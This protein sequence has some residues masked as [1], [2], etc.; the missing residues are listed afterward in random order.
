MSTLH[1]CSVGARRTS[2]PG[3]ACASTVSSD[4]KSSGWTRNISAPARPTAAIGWVLHHGYS[5]AIPQ[6]NLVKGFRLR[7]GDIQV[8]DYS[9]LED[10]FTEP[11]FNGWSVAEVHV[12][13]SR[14]VPNGRRDHFEQNTHYNNLLNQIAPYAR[15]ISKRCRMSSIQRKYLRDF[16]MHHEVATEKIDIITQGTLPPSPRKELA[17]SAERAIASME[18]IARMDGLDIGADEHLAPRV[19]AIKDRLNQAMGTPS[20]RSPLA[21]LPPTKRKM[22]EHLISLIYEC[23]MNRVAAKSLVDRIIDRVTSPN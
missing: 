21:D 22:Y 1:S 8:G 20:D 2:I 14:I 10:L 4:T 15:D 18:K 16:E 12:L 3:Q 13:D 5:G 17:R 6:S 9:L 7:V 19:K 23:S 11:E